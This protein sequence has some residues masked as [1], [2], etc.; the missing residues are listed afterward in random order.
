MLSRNFIGPSSIS[1]ELKNVQP[2]VDDSI[3][4]NIRS[5]YTVTEKADGMR[6]LFV[7]KKGKIYLIDTNMNIQLYGGNYINS[8]II[9]VLDGEHILH[10]KDGNY[11]NMYAAFDIYFIDKEDQRLKKFPDHTGSDEETTNFR[12]N[13]LSVYI[14][15]LKPK[16]IIK[17]GNILIIDRKGFQISL[18]E[19]IYLRD[20]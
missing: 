11:L 14:S 13:M 7:N 20:V 19:I 6:K 1:L 2:V 4:A 15:T 3:V 8:I 12:L 17:G 5:P 18:V 16:H 10:D 9:V